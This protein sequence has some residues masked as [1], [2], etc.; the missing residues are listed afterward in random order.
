LAR[1]VGV[2]QEQVVAVAAAIADRDGL[3]SVIL[4]RVAQDLGVRSPSLY[5]HV[6]GLAG[7][8]R[9]LNKAASRALAAAFAE[10]A[11]GAEHDEPVDQLRAIGRAYR[12]FAHQHSGL[13]AALLPAPRPDDDPEAAAAAADAL[14][15]VTAVLAR[16]D[17]PADRRVDVVRAIRALLHG[18]VDLELR[19]GFGLHDPVDPS[20]EAAL[21]LIVAAA[22]APARAQ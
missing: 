14:V 11:A 12:A 17:I 5:A 9:Q 1:K 18:F 19:G 15:E 7:L 4:A 13:Y 20:F 3:E 6:D 2:T 10:A 16:L 22:Q 8:R 21:D